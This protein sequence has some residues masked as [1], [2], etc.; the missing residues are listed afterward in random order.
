[1]AK[2]KAGLPEDFDL[3]VDS[4]ELVEGPVRLPGYLDRRSDRFIASEPSPARKAISARPS[5]L[6][7][8]PSKSDHGS[9]LDGIPKEEAFEE[10]VSDKKPRTP[11]R[12]LQINLSREAQAKIEELVEVIRAQSPEKGVNYNDVIQSLILSLYEA[13]A[14][15]DV[16]ELPLRG[17]WGS[18]TAKSF[19][20]ALAHLI[21]RALV[22]HSEIRG[23]PLRKVVGG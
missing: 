12:R 19:T 14:E 7:S 17:R 10:K 20:A 16:S 8:E 4:S 18:P 22:E 1:M 11:V 23:D 9:A 21:R 5:S 15:L 13:R 2:N 6:R 3:K